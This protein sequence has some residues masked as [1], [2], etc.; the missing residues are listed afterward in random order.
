M[1]TFT[2]FISFQ[3]VLL[4]SSSKSLSEIVTFFDYSTLLRIPQK[5]T[6]EDNIFESF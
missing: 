3:F 6:D 4:T 2:L 1:S 5:N